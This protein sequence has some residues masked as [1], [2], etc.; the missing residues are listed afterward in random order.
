MIAIKGS[1]E[2]PFYGSDSLVDT[3]PI[4]SESNKF[5]KKIAKALKDGSGAQKVRID[6]EADLP[7]SDVKKF[8][9]LSRGMSRYSVAVAGSTIMDIL[10]G[11]DSQ[12]ADIDIAVGNKDGNPKMNIHEDDLREY[13][14][15]CRGL[16][17]VSSSG[18]VLA[19]RIHLSSP[20]F[21]MRNNFGEWEFLKRTMSSQFTFEHFGLTNQG[22]VIAPYGGAADILSKTIRLAF[23]NPNFQEQHPT[24]CPGWLA[25]SHDSSLSYETGIRSLFPKYKWGFNFDPATQTILTEHTP[26]FHCSDYELELLA[27][28]TRW[29]SSP[30]RLISDLKRF[31]LLEGLRQASNSDDRVYTVVNMSTQ[32]M[33]LKSMKKDGYEVSQACMP[34]SQ[35]IMAFLQSLPTPV[36]KALGHELST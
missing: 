14:K 13:I 1:S 25:Y 21:L 18:G 33:E 20:H 35:R 17:E 30:L 4:P 23:L 24:R 9:I 6:I 10:L 32:D 12:L 27:R 28:L 36:S 3:K 2:K 34:R 29:V 16:F 8:L 26:V 5:A 7:D 22:E 11:R 19:D 31:H 15:S